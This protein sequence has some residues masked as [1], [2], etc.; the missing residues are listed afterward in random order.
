MIWRRL[1]EKIK[2]IRRRNQ[3]KILDLFPVYNSHWVVSSFY[4]GFYAL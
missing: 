3:I 2:Q 4:G 1:L